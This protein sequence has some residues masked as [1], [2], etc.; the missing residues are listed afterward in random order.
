MT[1]D[2]AAKVEFGR[3]RFLAVI[4]G[5]DMEHQQLASSCSSVPRA[6]VSGRDVAD[7]RTSRS[8]PHRVDDETGT[9]SPP[10]A[11]DFDRDELHE[12]DPAHFVIGPRH[13]QPAAGGGRAPDRRAEKRV[14]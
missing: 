5:R 8:R 6:R 12:A 11:A 3:C 14:I 13:A 9:Q 10:D 2:R 7:F 1:A 4:G